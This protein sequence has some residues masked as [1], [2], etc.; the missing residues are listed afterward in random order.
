MYWI[1][2]NVAKLSEIKHEST[3]FCIV[4]C[5]RGAGF[6]VFNTPQSGVYAEGKPPGK[7]QL[8]IQFT[9]VCKCEKS[10]FN[11]LTRYKNI[12]TIKKI[13]TGLEF[14]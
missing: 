4:N 8:T 1:F 11:T 2:E 14:Y 5:G 12:E 7:P 9:V 10:K 6:S 13:L 3:T